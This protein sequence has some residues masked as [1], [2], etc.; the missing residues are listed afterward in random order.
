LADLV[1]ALR[2]ALESLTS[3]TLVGWW[4]PALAYALLTTQAAIK[5]RVVSSYYGGAELVVA[6]S[7]GQLDFVVVG[8]ADVGPSL[9]GGGLR[10]LV[11]SVRT[12]AL[13]T[14]RSF[15]EQGWNVT[16]AWWRGLAA[17]AD[18]PAEVIGL[19]D[20]PLRWA[21]DS[22]ALRGEFGRSGLPVD[23][24][25][26]AAFAKFVLDEYQTIGGLF[27][28]LGLNVRVSKPA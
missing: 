20:A 25:D 13:P 10:A 8:L 21:L 4:P 28:L 24:L 26:A 6:L 1:S 3:G 12:P 9:A 5:P 16:T 11:V 14:A 18:T 17:P 23:P 22:E 27:S 19:L 2:A 7:Q 15:R